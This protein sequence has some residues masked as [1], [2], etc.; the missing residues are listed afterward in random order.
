MALDFAHAQLPTLQ[1]LAE[2]FT[3]NPIEADLK[4]L[5]LDLFQRYLAADLFD[6]NVLG[7]AQLG[8][9]ELVRKA[10]NRDGLVLVPGEHEEQ[11]TRY[12]Y[13][14]WKSMNTQGR[15]LHFL[16]TY[17]QLLYPRSSE[18]VQLLQDKSLPYTVGMLP[19]DGQSVPDGCFLSSRLR[20]TIDA[21]LSN[22]SV[23][24]V[25]AC[26][27][28]VIPAR[29][30][31][32]FQFALAAMSAPLRLAST[33][34]SVMMANLSGTLRYQSA[35]ASRSRAEVAHRGQ[36]MTLLT[37][38]GRL[39]AKPGSLIASELSTAHTWR[40]TSLLMATGRLITQPSHLTG[41]AF[42]TAHLHQQTLIVRIT[43][44]IK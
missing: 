13:R 9:L 31:T 26:V 37:T 34:T 12:L 21:S 8:S 22:R 19:F 11:A 15:G 33:F 18:V 14:A 25:A 17:L 6:A 41:T 30:V 28:S 24:D 36:A 16:R 35:P 2:S 4:Q 10:I 5:L 38:T 40:A 43:G 7:A 32:D 39:I 44:A 3:Q 29:F 27:H 20:V 1:A 23:L 42:T